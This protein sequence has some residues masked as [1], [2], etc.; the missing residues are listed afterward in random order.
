MNKTAVAQAGGVS[1]PLLWRLTFIVF[2]DQAEGDLLV[3]CYGRPLL[4]WEISIQHDL[5]RFFD[6][7]RG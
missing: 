1:H 2:A 6:Y 3:M 7:R 5:C 4:A